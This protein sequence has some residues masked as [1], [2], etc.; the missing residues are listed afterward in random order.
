MCAFITFTTQEAF[1]RCRKYLF[2]RDEK[3]KRNKDHD[4]LWLFDEETKMQGATEPSNIIWENLE[5]RAKKR[6]TREMI[7]GFA[8]FLFIMFTFVLF[9]ALKSYQGRNLLKYPEN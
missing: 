8:V 2:W 5:V 1:E 7:V 3:G 4:A 9:S 6:Y